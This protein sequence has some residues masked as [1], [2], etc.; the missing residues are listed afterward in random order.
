MEA[1]GL[2]AFDALGRGSP[3][4][5][6]EGRCLPSAGS[7]EPVSGWRALGYRVFEVGMPSAQLHAD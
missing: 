3:G 4:K 2:Q 5:G 1:A 7:W 6:G